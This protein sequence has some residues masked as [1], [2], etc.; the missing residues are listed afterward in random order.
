MT[1]NKASDL[2]NSIRD[3]VKAGTKKWTSVRK[4][5][6]RSPVSRRYRGE[7]MRRETT[8]KIKDVAW[9]IMETAY[10][11]ASGDGAY[12]ANAR[13]I[14]YAARG[15]IQEKTGKTLRDNYFTQQLLPDYV[16]ERGVDWDV[17]YDA[18]G[19]FEEPHGGEKFGIGTAEVRDY[20][21]KLRETPGVTDAFVDQATVQVL[22]PAGNFGGVLFIEKEGFDPLLKAA[23]IAARYDLA[24]MSTKGMS[25]TAARALVDE[26]CSRFDLRLFLLHDFDKAGFSIAGTLQ[27]DTR[28][29]EFKNSIEVIDLGLSLADVNEMGLESEY[30]H[31]QRGDRS[32]L[33]ANLRSNGA[34]EEEIAFMFRDFNE[35]SST[36]RV[37]LNAMTSPQFIAF[38]EHKLKESDVAKVV[39]DV[40]TLNETYIA[41]ERGRR[42]EEAT[43][44][45]LADIE[46]EEIEPPKNLEKRVRAMLKRKPAMRWDTAVAAVADPNRVETDSE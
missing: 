32:A 44:E 7:R 35:T 19:H 34:T 23:E 38:L 37:E 40:E 24:I 33:E 16:N 14:M 3:A 2:A 25:V 15:Y 5:E 29:Y 21:A 26:M 42:L 41:L 28:R 1:K 4:S 11:K 8:I 46:N 6:Q 12:P 17:I 39:P 9:E 45:V 20:L 22:G 36:R 18:R 31:H 13:Q 30:Q 10:M 43:E 27:R